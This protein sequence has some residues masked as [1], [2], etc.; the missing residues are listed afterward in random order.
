MANIKH[1]QLTAGKV[2]A[3]TAPGAYVDGEELTLRVS[4][5][6]TK[7]WVL[8][9]TI[10]GKRKNIGLGGYPSVGLAEARRLAE[11]HRQNIRDGVDPVEVKREAREAARLEPVIPTFKA[12]TLEVHR[13]NL[14]RL[15]TKN[16]KSWLQRAEKYALPPLGTLP[17]DKIGRQEVLAV[18]TPI[19]TTKPE[20]ARRVR[21][22]IKSVFNWAIAHEYL[23]M[24]PAGEGISP[25]LPS[26]PKVKDHFKALPYGELA[27]ALAC[28]DSSTAG[29]VTKLAVRF[30]ALTAA[31]SGEVRGCRWTEIDLPRKLWIIPASRMK[32]GAEHRVPLSQAALTVLEEAR[33]LQEDQPSELVFPS[34]VKGGERPLS[35]MTL[36]K[37]L[38]TTELADRMTIHGIRSS[39]RDW[40][41]EETVTPWAVAELALAHRV[42]TSVEQAYHRTDLLE[43]RRQL[44]DEWADFLAAPET[45]G[46][47]D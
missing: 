6:G 16:S 47:S 37:V 27:A 43:K 24:N 11:K 12:A 46:I 45:E 25:A 23:E 31:R 3:I 18:L 9:A 7:S 34:P 26:Q 20:T 42:G 4:D 33:G 44:M 28:I 19:W 38:R 22:I 40:T 10:G 17:I 13:L 8:R 2:K 1:A 39:F 14:T 29:K 36:T 15:S 41:S 35:D 21:H 32:S 30:L 5:S